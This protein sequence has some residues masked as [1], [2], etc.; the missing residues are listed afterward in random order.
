MTLNDS[1]LPPEIDAKLRNPRVGQ[2]VNELMEAKMTPQE[3]A[4]AMDGRVSPRTIYRWAKNETYPQNDRDLRALEKLHAQTVC[5]V[6]A[7]QL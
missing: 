7:D 3:I 2:M 5:K 6:E 1:D 4:E